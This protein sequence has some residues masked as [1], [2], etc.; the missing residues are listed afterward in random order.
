MGRPADIFPRNKN[1]RLYSWY[2]MVGDKRVNLKTK[3]VPEARRRRKL[4]LVGQWPPP[5][6]AAADATKSAFANQGPVVPP[7]PPVVDAPVA[8]E[9]AP[10]PAVDQPAA[11][12]AVEWTQ[13]ATAAGADAAK[14]LE[15]EVVDPKVE[16]EARAEDNAEVAKVFVFLQTALTT[17]I[18]RARVYD[19]FEPP[20][21]PPEGQAAL[22]APYKTML[23]YGGAAVALPP[24]V[25]GLALPA[26]T[27]L[28]SAVVMFKLYAAEA[29]RQKAE[30]AHAQPAAAA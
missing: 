2:T 12:P 25:R 27:A 6:V 3:D 18:V 13:A 24:W 11:A 16:Q 9:R 1:G 28:T 17:G 22:A 14:P 29:R 26:F 5:E 10:A 30:G 21:L 8:A 23:D 20:E 15:P 7:P 19:R 4:A